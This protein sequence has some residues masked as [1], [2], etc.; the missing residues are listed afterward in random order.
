MKVLFFTL[1]YM[2][3]SCEQTNCQEAVIDGNIYIYEFAIKKPGRANLGFVIVDS[4]LYQKV[5][6]DIHFSK[7]QITKVTRTISPS[8]SD[9]KITKRLGSFY[10]SSEDFV[11]KRRLIP[12]NVYKMISIAFLEMTN[13]ERLKILNE[14]SMK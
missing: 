14:L 10:Y 7:D 6:F 9:N 8:H 1:L 2:L 12:D 4:N 3:N 5:S 11:N 13:K